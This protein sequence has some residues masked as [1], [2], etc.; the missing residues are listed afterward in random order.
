MSAAS[1][2]AAELVPSSSADPSPVVTGYRGTLVSLD[3]TAS[4]TITGARVRVGQDVWPVDSLSGPFMA[5]ALADQFGLVGR[6][7]R[8]FVVAGQYEI[9]YTLST[10]SLGS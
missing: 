10:L 9:A 3:S 6:T 7:V 8:V 2:L 1:D 4:G 5:E